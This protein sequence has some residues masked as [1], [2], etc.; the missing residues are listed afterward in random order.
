MTTTCSLSFPRTPS[1]WTRNSVFSRRDASCSPWLRSLRMLSIWTTHRAQTS[2]TAYT[3]NYCIDLDDTQST[4]QFCI[5]T[6]S[7]CTAP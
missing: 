4:T 3:G 6:E 2:N 1:N 7:Y 5:D